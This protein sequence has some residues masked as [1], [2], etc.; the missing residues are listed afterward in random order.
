MRRLR[1]WI[2]R[3]L[4]LVLAA[5]GLLGWIGAGHLVSPERRTLQEYHREIL[6][7]PARFG[8]AIQSFKG[9]RST[10][11]LLVRPRPGGEARKSRQ[12]RSRLA[13]D[14]IPLPPWGEERGTI[15]LLHGHG[16]RKEDHLPICERFCAAGFRCLILDLPGH[17]EH[18]DRRA[19][20]GH[21]EA[22]LVVEVLDDCA[23]RFG[24][25][26][27]PVSLF[28]VSQGGA[29]ALR[30]AAR[31][32]DR[33]AA[34]A[35]VASFAGLDETLAAAARELHPLLRPVAPLSSQAVG[36]ATLLRGGFHPS[37]IRPLDDAAKIRIP[38]LIV[39]G[40]EDRMIPPCDARRIHQ[41]LREPR[42]PLRW[43]DDADHQSILGKDAANLYPD[44]CRHFLGA[45]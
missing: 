27:G 43:V 8:L 42:A 31:H 15:V 28:G 29:I 39:H 2:L 23:T 21:R 36:L 33:F 38:T 24:F 5:F 9:A 34:V 20:F 7:E 3:L 12:L 37:A 10:P 45:G 35:S 32:D 30:C 4:L 1:A 44:L 19:S 11:C 25:P 13:D 41:A 16:G 6:A 22:D 14:R 26:P 17:G 18:P 40:R